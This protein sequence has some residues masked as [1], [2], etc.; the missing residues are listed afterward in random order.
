MAKVLVVTYSWTGTSLQ[1]SALL[2]A[3][4]GWPSGEV[5]DHK[6][7]AGAWGMLRCVLDSVLERKPPIRYEGPDPREFDVTVL[8]SPVWAYRLAGP[9]RTFVNARR[10]QLRQV[11]VISVMGQNGAANAVAEI[12]HR[13]GRS[14]SMSVAF[15]AREVED[16]SCAAR[17]Q[18]FAQAVSSAGDDGAVRPAT[19]SPRAA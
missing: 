5:L 16:G 13:I 11:A 9:M 4:T 1:L 18:A 19:W 8:V 17:L 3:A 15:T 10:G 7:R 6:R 12:G 2:C 14:P